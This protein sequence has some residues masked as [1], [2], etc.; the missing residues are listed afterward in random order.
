MRSRL[1]RL[2]ST[3]LSRERWRVGTACR[4]PWLVGR[5]GRVGEALGKVTRPGKKTRLLHECVGR[6]LLVAHGVENPIVRSRSEEVE[7]I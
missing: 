4:C 7:K 3:G 6:R 1:Q 5:M 2:W